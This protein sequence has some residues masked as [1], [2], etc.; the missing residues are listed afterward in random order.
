MTWHLLISPCKPTS[1]GATSEVVATFHTDA[2]HVTLHDKA[3][4]AERH[5]GTGNP[6]KELIADLTS[7]GVQVELCGATAR[8][9]HWGNEDLLPGIKVN[10]D[11]GAQDDSAHPPR[12]REN[13]RIGTGPRREDC[14]FIDDVSS[15]DRQSLATAYALAFGVRLQPRCR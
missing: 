1:S 12:F 5:M 6:N 2:G 11:A 8:I 14:F 9:H 3:Y 7:R 4:N 10:T 13:H 15:A